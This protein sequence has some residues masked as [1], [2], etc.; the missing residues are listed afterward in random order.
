MKAAWDLSFVAFDGFAP[1]ID[2]VRPEGRFLVGVK[3]LSCCV[4]SRIACPVLPSRPVLAS[5]RWKN[6]VEKHVADFS[7]V[8]AV[9]C[10]VERDPMT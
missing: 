6:P 10:D 1:R 9:S 3:Q 8:R 7:A 5:T 4:L 2:G